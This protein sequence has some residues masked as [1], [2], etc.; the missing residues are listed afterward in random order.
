MEDVTAQVNLIHE[1]KCKE[2][3]RG[4]QAGIVEGSLSNGFKCTPAA[5]PQSTA[6]SAF[7]R[8][9]GKPCVSRAFH[10]FCAH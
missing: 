4:G 2:L 3:K 8:E 10:S 7:Q 1:I 9:A 5:P 6:T